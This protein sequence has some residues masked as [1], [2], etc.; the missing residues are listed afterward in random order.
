MKRCNVVRLLF[1]N[2]Q[3]EI[4]EILGDRSA[5]L[6]NAVTYKYRQAFFTGEPLPSYE[7]LC[8]EFKD[9]PAY[10][11]LPADMGPERKPKPE[12]CLPGSSGINLLPRKPRLFPLMVPPKGRSTQ[13]WI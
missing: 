4:L 11:A 3:A 10:K 5:D 13:C 7:A 12:K 1:S 2:E 9:H 6:W 8:V